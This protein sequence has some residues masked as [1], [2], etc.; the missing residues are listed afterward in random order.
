MCKVSVIINCLNG[1]KYLRDT[2]ESLREQTFTD[3]EVI[4][5]DNCSSDATGDIAKSFGDKMKY[6]RG[7]KTV[8]LGEARNLAIDKASGEYISFLDSDDLWEP[9]KIMEQV[10]ELDENPYVGLVCTNYYLLNMMTNKKWVFDDK[11]SRRVMNFSSFVDHY[12]YC[13]S[14]FM[15]RK[16]AIDELD[17]YFSNELKYAEEFELFVRIALKWD[18]VFLPTPF[19]TYRI[20][21]AMNSMHLI[22]VQYKEYDS[23]LNTL[24]NVEPDIGSKYPNVVKWISFVRDL[25]GTKA[26]IRNGNNKKVRELM[27]PYLNYNIRAK[28]FFGVSLLPSPVSKTIVNC[29]YRKRF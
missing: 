8:P 6:Y 26:E 3:Y 2:L 20:H 7:T 27:K 4:F 5:W 9:N 28:C 10:K 15:I 14:T 19:V 25:A 12:S 23:I 1:E 11:A 17:H 18:T 22:D 13:F 29:F 24:K 16:K 21:S